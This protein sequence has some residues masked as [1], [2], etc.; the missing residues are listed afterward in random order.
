MISPYVTD[1][2]D[3]IV[4]PL[5]V[6]VAIFLFGKY[7]SDKRVKSNAIRNLMT[8]RGGDFVNPDFRKALNKV[9]IT[10]SK[11]PKVREQIRELYELIN[12]EATKEEV[13]KRKIVSVIYYLCL[14]Y[15]FKDMSE[16]DID[17]SFPEERQKPQ[18]SALIGTTVLDPVDPNKPT[19][20]K[21]QTGRRS[22]G[23]SNSDTV[24]LASKVLKK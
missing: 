18:E 12:S 19:G 20:T 17:Q 22:N 5:A 3:I 9:S 7:E 8:N 6:G 23:T 21:P 4:G 13:I 14:N 1:F 16:Y 24:S 15:G 10:F 11:D 2:L